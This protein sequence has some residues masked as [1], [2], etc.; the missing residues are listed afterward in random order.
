MAGEMIARAI[1]EGDDRWRLFSPYELVWAGGRSGRTV[2]Q[3]LLWSTRARGALKEKLARYRDRARREADARQ[4][5]FEAERAMRKAEAE[6]MRA[7]EESRRVA[8]QEAQRLRPRRRGARLRNG[9]GKR[10][11]RRGLRRK[12]RR[13]PSNW[14]SANTSRQCTRPPKRRRAMPP[15]PQRC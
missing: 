9:R 5:R 4:I 2:V 3:M 14:R 12:R 13:V 10:P 1:L 15:K 8:E 11:T 7:E 6:R